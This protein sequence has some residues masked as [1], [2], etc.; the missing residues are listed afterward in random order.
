MSRTARSPPQPSRLE[1]AS[2]A[3]AAAVVCADPS[4]VCCIHRGGNSDRARGV[5]A[6]EWE[7]TRRSVKGERQGHARRNNAKAESE[8]V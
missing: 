6:A 7:R 5:G 8:K 1:C 4:V 3:A 2:A